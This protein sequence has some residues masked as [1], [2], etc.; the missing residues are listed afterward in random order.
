MICNPS[1]Q[2]IYKSHDLLKQAK[3]VTFGKIKTKEPARVI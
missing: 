3:G 1:V 2:N